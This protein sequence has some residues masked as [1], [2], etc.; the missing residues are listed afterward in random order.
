LHN[1]QKAESE[2]AL[3]QNFAYQFGGA[4]EVRSDKATGLLSVAGDYCLHE[5]AVF[6]IAIAT[7]HPGHAADVSVAL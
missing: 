2:P 5:R 6:W 7:F 1:A 3:F 4:L